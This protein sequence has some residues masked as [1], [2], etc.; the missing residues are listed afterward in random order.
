MNDGHVPKFPWIVHHCTN[1]SHSLIIMFG[2]GGFP[3]LHQVFSCMYQTSVQP[4][5]VTSYIRYL[6]PL[7][8]C[9]AQVFLQVPLHC[10][11]LQW[12]VNNENLCKITMDGIHCAFVRNLKLWTNTS[13]WMYA[14]S[15]TFCCE[16][17]LPFKMSPT[18]L[19]GI[20]TDVVA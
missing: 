10:Q 6:P 13:K 7:L 8:S 15:F 9:R 2:M 19:M 11:M 18:S 1:F 5:Y 4:C 20:L 14:T 3:V 12:W 16:Y 17:V